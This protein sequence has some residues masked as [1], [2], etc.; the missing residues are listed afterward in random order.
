MSF[1]IGVDGGGTK[2]ECILVDAS[3]VVAGRHMAPGCNPS[4]VGP[5]QA[6]ALLLE[7]MQA[8]RVQSRIPQLKLEI[9]TTLLC[10]A[11]SQPFWRETAAQLGGF[12]RIEA[13]PDS[14][15][16]LELAT[17]GAP[18]LVVHAGTGSFVAARAPDGSA[19]Y[20][21][22]LGWRFGDSGSGYDLGRRAVAR[23]LLELQGWA[24]HT[25][26]AEALCQYTGLSDY[27]AN[28]GLFYADAAANAKIAAFAPRAIELAEQGCGAAQQ[29]I[30]E[31]L[32]G[33]AALVH[34]VLQQLFPRATAGAALPCGV[35]GALLN[36]PACRS[37]LRAFAATHAWPV[38]LQ[39]ITD[40]PIEGVRRLL[41]K[42]E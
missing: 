32:G 1:K 5:D 28:S 15:P 19:H 2:T 39:P 8:V 20:A 12:G 24:E 40:P 34:R 21:G 36:R 30:A 42:M 18:G 25:A 31:S 33:L 17:G 3:G 6:R 23:A 14:L 4:V 11:G 22:G 27:A 29:I 16:V 26:L 35:S 38:Q 10:M 37:A 41:L 13:A 9:T 7:A